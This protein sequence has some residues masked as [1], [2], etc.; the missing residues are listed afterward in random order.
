MNVAHAT[1]SLIVREMHRR[2][3]HD[4]RMVVRA[5]NAIEKALEVPEVRGT[6]DGNLM[7]YMALYEATGFASAVV[8]PYMETYAMCIEK[9]HLKKLYAVCENILKYDP[10]PLV[11]IHDQ[12]STLPNG[13]NAVRFHYKE[14]MAEIAEGKILDK[15]F[16]QI[17]GQEVIYKKLGN[18][19]ENIRKSEYAL[20]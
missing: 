15:I 7:R 2:V 12:F 16:S 19:S 17:L 6:V 8:L 4:K 11:S 10:M 9:A 3:N 18:I 20:C 13:V 5:F 1:D 14:I